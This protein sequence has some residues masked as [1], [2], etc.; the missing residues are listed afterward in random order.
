MWIS[1]GTKIQ[2]IGDQIVEA[3]FNLGLAELVGILDALGLDANGICLPVEG[4]PG[5][6]GDLARL[7]GELPV[8]CTMV[9][10][11][12]GLD[13]VPGKLDLYDAVDDITAGKCCQLAVAEH[14]LDL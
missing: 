13:R 9:E 7:P 10:A 14:A 5:A 11:V 4:G 6:S 1:D 2:K 12:P 8:L 3:D